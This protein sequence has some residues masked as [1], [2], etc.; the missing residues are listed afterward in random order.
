MARI[1]KFPYTGR[2]IRAVDLSEFTKEVPVSAWRCM[3]EKH[4][5]EAAIIQLWGGGFR[6]GR[7]NF[8]FHQAVDAALEAGIHK[9][10]AYVWPPKDWGKAL[11]WGGDHMRYMSAVALDMEAGAPISQVDVHGVED[12]GY[13]AWVYTN[14]RDW[15]ELMQ[16]VHSFNGNPLWLARYKW[17]A[18]PRTGFYRARWDASIT[19]AFGRTPGLGGWALGELAGW[20]FTGTVVDFC[21][22]SV[23]L[24][25]MRE[26]AFTVLN[27]GENM[28]E[29][30]QDIALRKI[31]G[32]LKKRVE[33]TDERVDVL[34]ERV[35]SLEEDTL[36]QAE[37][38][39]GLAGIG[40]PSG[41]DAHAADPDAHHE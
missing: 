31:V 22:E 41:L 3:R 9:L 32:D 23:D 25:L 27:G 24:N 30:V 16:G 1:Y 36:E 21:G 33:A 17:L 35:D 12:A 19:E 5:V 29:E 15:L 11:D 40:D 10:A 2:V 26:D 18:D 38:T 4:G 34:E 28:P 37:I 39:D 7:A 20:Q 6:G 14:P 8:Y 13:D